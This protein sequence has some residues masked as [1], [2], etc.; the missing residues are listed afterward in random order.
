MAVLFLASLAGALVCAHEYGPS[1]APIP[2]P[3]EDGPACIPPSP[4]P[5]RRFSLV[6]LCS[7]LLPPT[8]FSTQGPVPAGQRKPGDLWHPPGS[9]A[10]S[11]R[12]LW[13]AHSA[14]AS[15]AVF[16]PPLSQTISHLPRLLHLLAHPPLHSFT[17]PLSTPTLSNLQACPS[18]RQWIS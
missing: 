4:R 2:W 12:S 15:L 3:P 8:G 9:T 11:P 17:H 1:P 13:F 18:P 10:T 7:P 5:Q 14:P 16:S 6:C